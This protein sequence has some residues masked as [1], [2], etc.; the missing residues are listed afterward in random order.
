MK[1]L[2]FA[3][4]ST[5]HSGVLDPGVLG[6]PL[7]SSSSVT[8]TMMPVYTPLNRCRLRVG[9]LNVRCLLSCADEVAHIAFSNDFDI[10][11]LNETWLDD[12]VLNA[13]VCPPG[14]KLIRNDRNK[15]GGGVAIM[16][17]DSVCF[18][19]PVISQGKLE[20]IWI[21]LFPS[22]NRRSVLLCCAYRP[23]SSSYVFL[24]I[25]WLSVIIFCLFEKR[26]G[27]LFS[28]T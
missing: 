13:E 25:C 15:Q 1:D 24:T 28:V 6:S 17:S 16:I 14:W 9:L 27:L 10:I 4:C 18:S 19:R 8:G 12:S 2:P 20:S 22:S 21:E 3:D 26:N 23:P 5:L 7:S 11:C